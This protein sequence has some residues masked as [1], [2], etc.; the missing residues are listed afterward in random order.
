MTVDMTKWQD[1]AR[2]NA[3]TPYRKRPYGGKDMHSDRRGPGLRQGHSAGALQRGRLD[4]HSGLNEPLAGQVAAEM[5]ERAFAVAV[6]VSDEESVANMV[7]QT[8]ERFGGIDLMLSNAGSG[9][10]WPRD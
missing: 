5:G 10:L 3:Q 8:V 7:A 2:A 9:T 6:N 1:M 4:S